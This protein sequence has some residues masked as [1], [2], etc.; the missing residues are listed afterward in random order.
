VRVGTQ[1]RFILYFFTLAFGPMHAARAQ[2]T[3]QTAR[4]ALAGI[5]EWAHGVDSTLPRMRRTRIALPGASSEGAELTAYAM[6]DSLRKLVAV[7]ARETGK[8]TEFYYVD[9]NKLR[10]YTR[11]ESRYD[12]PM[13][14]RVVKSTVERMWFV[15]DSAIA[16]R[17]TLGMLSTR[18]RAFTARRV[19]ALRD[20][21]N[22][23]HFA[24]PRRK[25]PR[26]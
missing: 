14:G 24:G 25:S 19:D 13:S 26:G 4:P 18:G 8:T 5:S 21:K 12:R 11:T 3:R 15:G 1:R 9:A 7:Y 2:Q 20:F 16:W 6:G 23:I 10:L 17:D 22:A